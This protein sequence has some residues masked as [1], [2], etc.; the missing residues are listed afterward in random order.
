MPLQI[1]LLL[2]ASILSLA[3][4]RRAVPFA[5]TNPCGFPAARWELPEKI[6]TSG[7]VLIF[8]A[9]AVVSAGQKS[10]K[11]DMG[12]LGASLV[13][14]VALVLLVIGFLVFRDHDIRA[15]FGLGVRGWNWRTITGWLLMFL[16]LVYFVQS[17]SYAFSSPDQGPQAIVEFLLKSSGWQA[18]AAVFGIAVIAAP[19][20]EELIFRGC[21]Y[22]VLRK[23][24]GRWPAIVVSSIVFALIHGH[25]PALP[26]LFLLAVGLALVYERCGSLWAPIA[27]HAAFNGLTI[28]AAIFLPDLAK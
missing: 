2:I 6:F 28:V 26:G 1:P 25:L 5:L 18:R 27:M 4:L 23:S 3:F 19:V 10:G 22:G 20:T 11:I 15:T 8:L 7:L 9:L 13:L 16:P 12:S 24:S 21:L 14:Y 17:L